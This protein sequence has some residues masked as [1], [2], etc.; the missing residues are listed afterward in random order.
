[1]NGRAVDPMKYVVPE[2]I[3]VL[4]RP[5]RTDGEG[6]VQEPVVGYH[7]RHQP[8]LRAQAAQG[9]FAQVDAIQ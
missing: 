4:E 8:D 1:M 2:T 9:Q 3:T 5:T 7:L 6:S